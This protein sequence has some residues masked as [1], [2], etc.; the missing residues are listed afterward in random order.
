M[1]REMIINAEDEECRIAVLEDGQLE[2]LYLERASLASHV[3]NIYKG[4][5][6]NVEKSIQAAF[7][8]FGLPKQGFLHISDLHSQH[9]PSKKAT[10]TESIEPVGRK[11]SRRQ[12]P[13]IQNCLKRGQDIIVQVIKQG[14]GTKGPTLSSY[15]SLPGRF[16]IMMPGMRRSG[17]SRKIENEDDRRQ[18]KDL[19]ESL[20][21]PK[22]YGFIVRTAGL[23]RGKRDMNADL[24]YLL[25]LWKA[26]SKRVK[27]EQAPCELYRESDLVIRT[28]RDVFSSDISQIVTDN[29]DVA[30][31]IRDF[32]KAA[33]PRSLRKVKLY[34]G[35]KPLFHQYKIEPEIDKIHSRRVALPSGGSIV[36]DPTEALV[37]IDVNSG[38]S[39]AHGNAE[40]MAYNINKQAAPEIARQLRLRDLGGLII[41]DFIDM[42][43]AKHRRDVE[44][45]LHEA[46]KNDR[47][48][49]KTLRMSQFGIIEMTRQRLRPSL[50]SS[51]Y[52]ECPRCSG[53][54]LVKSAQSVTLDA[55]RA[56]KL[57]LNHD[58]VA[59][60]ELRL[61]P[62]AAHHIQNTN[63]QWL[64]ELE[65]SSG[66][67]ITIL[68]DDACGQ[69][70]FQF[71][72]QNARGSKVAVKI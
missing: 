27:N 41:C 25:R 11:K 42:I 65:K 55:M 28:I 54:G 34:D 1:P 12:R 59:S 17:V 38:K 64:A 50:S 48:H 29:P 56:L 32:L 24:N 7:V 23:G 20:K 36:I 5:V 53:A 19:L 44:K 46:M 16:L 9:F 66:R 26:V 58:D 6:T 68:P 45:V 69:D 13:P 39:R 71:H 47:A 60:V 43:N 35:S 2:E 51:V 15:I 22:N 33:M 70:E 52:E 57:V 21:P 4:R 63:R 18:L 72:C 14:V 37:A 31:R 62:P 10:S 49:S 30:A 61:S 67:T 8:D 40:A 3:G